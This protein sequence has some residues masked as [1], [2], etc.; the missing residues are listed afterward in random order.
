MRRTTYRSHPT[1][2][3]RSIAPARVTPHMPQSRRWRSTHT[4]PHLPHGRFGPLLAPPWW[5]AFAF[6]CV[7]RTTHTRAALRKQTRNR[8]ILLTAL[9][10]TQS[11]S[12]G[13]FATVSSCGLRLGQ[14]VLDG[15]APKDNGRLVLQ[16]RGC[17]RRCGEHITAV[18]E[19]DASH[20]SHGSRGGAPQHARAG[21]R[22]NCSNVDLREREEEE[23]GG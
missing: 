5:S 7:Q 18:R 10:P 22:P 3:C 20:V 11:L 15:S 4:S 14:K 16:S 21:R 9:T 8:P 2:M 1:G 13:C 6:F 17:V 23:G 12:H 19:Q